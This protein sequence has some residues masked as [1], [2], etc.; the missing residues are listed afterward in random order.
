ME[1]RVAAV[2]GANTGIGFET[3]KDLYGR[4]AKVI[5]L[6]RNKE[7]AGEAA[8]AI[9]WVIANFLFGNTANKRAAGFCQHHS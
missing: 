7:R 1:G 9:R 3:A 5:M 6:C 2:T 4:G 8:E